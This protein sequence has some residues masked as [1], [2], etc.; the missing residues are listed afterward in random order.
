MRY[1]KQAVKPISLF[2]KSRLNACLR[3][4]RATQRGSSSNRRLHYGA[5]GG[6]RCK[7]PPLEAKAN[8][9]GLQLINKAR[10]EHREPLLKDALLQNIPYTALLNNIYTMK[11]KTFI[12]APAPYKR[13]ITAAVKAFT[14]ALSPCHFHPKGCSVNF[15]LADDATIHQLNKTYRGK[16]RPT[17]VLSFPTDPADPTLALQPHYPLGDIIFA[18]ETLQREAA[19]FGKSYT[20]HLQH[21]TVH[22]LLHLLGYDHELGP[23]EA[24]LMA[25]TEVFILKQ[26][27]IPNPYT[28]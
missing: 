20:H 18:H 19:A 25:A 2:I 22:G 9:I 11:L 26:L 21:L 8:F 17:N 28:E 13:A 4:V 10:A 7:P 3:Q 23:E 27:D 15:V 1:C 14:E 5:L 6:L 12:D 16:D 24:E